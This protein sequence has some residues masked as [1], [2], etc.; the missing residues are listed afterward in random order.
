M[1]VIYSD[2][3]ELAAYEKELE[4]ACIVSGVKVLSEGEGEY[5][6]GTVSVTVTHKDGES[7]ARCWRYD[8]T[9]GTD[10]DH[11]HLCSR[12]ASV[13]RLNL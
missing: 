9:V 12:C 10:K 4:S 8:D 6:G 13:V 1:V 11:P 3:K 7:C 2:D 5:K